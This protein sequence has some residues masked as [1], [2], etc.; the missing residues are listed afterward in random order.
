MLYITTEP[1]MLAGI[2]EE[3]INDCFP[4]MGTYDSKRT[5]KIPPDTGIRLDSNGRVESIDI[6]I[7]CGMSMYQGTFAPHGNLKGLIGSKLKPIDENEYQAIVK[8]KEENQKRQE[9]RSE[10]ILRA[11]EERSDIN[12]EYQC[13]QRE[14]NNLD[15]ISK[16]AYE[17][18]SGQLFKNAILYVESIAKFAKLNMAVQEK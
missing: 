18:L 8:F 15:R 6:E 14:I 16:E 9:Y 3:L 7:K 1:I 2:Y 10:L 12:H 13:L 11:I 17:K 4:S 5:V